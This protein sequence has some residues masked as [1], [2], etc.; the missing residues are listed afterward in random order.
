MNRWRTIGI[1]EHWDILEAAGWR[2]EVRT[3]IPLRGRPDW[4]DLYGH[5][6]NLRYS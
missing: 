3:M 1:R 6:P 2:S 5:L 4:I